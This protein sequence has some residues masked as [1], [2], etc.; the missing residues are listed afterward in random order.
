MFL[1]NSNTR[2][3]TKIV[4]IAIIFVAA[5]SSYA[6]VDVEDVRHSSIVC[7]ADKEFIL[8][9]DY[10]YS[11]RLDVK[12]VQLAIDGIDIQVKAEDYKTFPSTKGQTTSILILVDVSDPKRRKTVSVFKWFETDGLIS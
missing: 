5:N 8:T 12:D 1:E 4:S 9:C 7:S 10:R 6:G 2:V 11:A 3:I